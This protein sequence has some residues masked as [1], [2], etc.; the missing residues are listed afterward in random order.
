MANDNKL[1]G[2]FDLIG[3]PP[4][5]RGLP[6]VEVTFDIDANGIVHVN[7][8]DLGTGKEQSIRITASSGLSEDE[9]KR[10]VKDAE[11]HAGED[12]KRRAA[13]EA[14]NQLDSLTYQTEKNLSEHGGDLD[15]EAKS[16]LESAIADA[17]KALEGGDAAAMQAATEALTKAQHKLAEKM[18]QKAA[19]SGAAG[20]GT[21]E[22]AAAS[23]A[24]SSAPRGGDD[25]VDADFEE[26]KE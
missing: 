18:Y 15:A 9:I 21:T 25:V 13:A 17:K 5:P 10:M 8:K 14:R 1:L 3:I 16:A 2:Q 24:G 26:V 12:S 4:A 7:A 19:Q 22:G 20:A 23:S 6:Q 11:A